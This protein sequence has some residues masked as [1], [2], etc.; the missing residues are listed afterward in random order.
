MSESKVDYLRKLAVVYRKLT[1]ITSDS[2][3]YPSW[4]RNLDLALFLLCSSNVTSKKEITKNVIKTFKNEDMYDIL[5][6]LKNCTCC[7]NCS[8]KVKNKINGECICPCWTLY[9]IFLRSLQENAKTKKY[10]LD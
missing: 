10:Q 6:A 3:R 9:N 1:I 5:I 4:V 7:E 8:D 2:R